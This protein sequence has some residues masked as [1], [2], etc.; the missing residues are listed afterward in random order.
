MPTPI[1]PAT[2][3]SSV[4]MR[5]FWY[6]HRREIAIGFVLLLLAATGWGIFRFY[7]SKRDNDAQAQ[8]SAAATAD[9]FKRVIS[10]FGGTPA[11][12]S[13][14][15]M[16]AGKQRTEGKFA[17]ANNTLQEFIE[18]NPK[19]ELVP[20]AKIAMAADLESL[21]KTD[22]ALS[23]Y[24]QIAAA[25]PRSFTAPL[26]LI[27][28]VPLLKEKH[29]PEAARRACETIVSQYP[30]SFW[31]GEAARELRTLK[32]AVAASPTPAAPNLVPPAVPP[33]SLQPSPKK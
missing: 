32:A 2:T 30:D 4:E 1:S 29:Q 6:H 31:A 27:S 13:A 12:G 10:Q 22:E 28:Q 21:N 24:Q 3:D 15:L 25:Y 9:D 5:V 18:K 7:S 17:E 33:A 16:L 23:L 8:L 20:S 14:Y 11:G 19:H 26:A